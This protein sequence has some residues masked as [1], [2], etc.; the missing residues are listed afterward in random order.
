[1]QKKHVNLLMNYDLLLPLFLL[2]LLSCFVQY[3]IAANEA[4]NAWVAGGKQALFILVGY[5][6]MFIASRINQK[7][8]W[9]LAPYFYFLTLLLMASL[10]VLYDPTMYQ[11]TG[12]K[13]WLDLGVVK[14][15]PSEIAKIA[16]ILMLSKVIVTHEQGAFLTKLQAD[17]S[18]IKKMCLWSLPVFLLMAVQ[19]DFGTSLV[20]LTILL[21]LFVVAGIDKKILWAIFTILAA[22]GCLLI[23]LV[24]TS[25]GNQILFMLHFKQ[26]QLNRI[27]AWLHPLEYADHISFQQVQGLLAVGSGGLFGKGVHG[28]QV[29]VPVRE[30]D[31]VFT[32]IAEAWGFVGST[33]IVFLY[34]ML[35]YQIVI[36]GLK[37]NSRFCLYICVGFLFSLGF[38]TIENIGAVI[39]LLPLKGI[40]LPFL[41][42]GGTS[43]VMAISALGF[44]KRP[45][46]KA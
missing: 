26:Y 22:L 19:K 7:M 23:L 31:M 29:Y 20:F 13:R 39:G 46:A 33:A 2:T 37:S 9:Q 30:S 36:A 21:A 32:F 38:Q 17:F 35:F 4:H 3:W 11:L 18:L 15:Q 6:G 44:I 8:I 12:T 42:Q 43:L 27:L 1:M 14:F 28:V 40:P 16:Y 5:L 41:S 10:Y 24:F 25:W 45:N 34:F